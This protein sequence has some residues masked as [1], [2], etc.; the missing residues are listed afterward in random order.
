MKAAES[1]PGRKGETGHRAQ[2]VRGDRCSESH[3]REN[4]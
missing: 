1:F 4:F 3:R 2:L